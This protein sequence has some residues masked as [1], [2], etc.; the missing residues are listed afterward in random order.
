MPV[1]RILAARDR[2]PALSRT[3]RLQSQAR[4]VKLAEGGCVRTPHPSD[5]A[6]IRRDDA[7]CRFVTGTCVGRVTGASAASAV[8]DAGA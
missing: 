4:N 2:L 1:T 7:N 5:G 3:K 8:L 6:R